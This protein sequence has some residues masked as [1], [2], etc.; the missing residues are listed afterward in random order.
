MTDPVKANHKKR[1]II[2]FAIWC[3]I[4]LALGIRLGW[5]ML[6]DGEEYSNRAVAQ[7][8]KDT[9]LAA[10]RGYIYDRNMKELAVNAPTYTVWVRPSELKEKEGRPG[11]MANLIAS[12]MDGDPIEIAKTLRKESTLVRVAKNLDSAQAEKIRGYI[13]DGRLPGISIDESTRRYYPYG[14]FAACVIGHI[15]DDGNG[16]AGLELAYNSYLSG[17]PG[18][19]IRNTD[20]SGRPLFNGTE[21]YYESENGLNLVLTLDEVLQHYLE[22]TLET[23]YEETGADATMGISM[24]INTGEILAMAYYP[25]YDLNAPRQPLA[26]KEIEAYDELETDEEKVQYW[27]HMW[28]NFMVSDTY[29][30]GSTFKVI[31]TAIALEEGLTN[32]NESFFCNGAYQLY[33]DT[34]TCRYHGAET[35]TQ[36]IQNSCNVVSITL[37]LRIGAQKY[38]EYMDALGFTAVTQV[39]LPSETSSI[40]YDPDKMV[41]GELATMTYGQGIAVT[42][43]QLIT[44]VTCCIPMS[45][46]RS[47][48][49]TDR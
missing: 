20:S 15:N 4:L 27:N 13:K 37:G 7:Q 21:R 45:S 39:D 23:A 38:F 31:T 42:P 35:L 22:T 5:I 32:T 14:P 16:V 8:T 34:F 46:A 30:P 9:Q 3:S 40:L 28:R 2:L 19:V 1:A 25:D 49:T 6:V 12:A 17:T 44:A 48:M 11:K 10:N 26:D 41:P 36:A 24:N 18:R 43:V 47:G 33:T 29:E